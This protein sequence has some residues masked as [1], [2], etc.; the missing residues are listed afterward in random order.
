MYQ[1]PK[2]TSKIG[3]TSPTLNL[4]PPPLPSLPH[5]DHPRRD[6]EPHP[7]NQARP[8]EPLGAI[9]PSPH[10]ANN[11][12][13]NRVPRQHGKTHNREHHPHPRALLPQ[14]R[15]Q[16]TQPRGEQTL[17]RARRDAVHAR[18]AVQLGRRVHGHPREQAH[19]A[20]EAR[21]DH[22]IQGPDLIREMI[23]E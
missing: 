14:I 2:S 15:R 13:G 1:Y 7:H 19:A 9:I 21:R 11:S 18:P 4:H 5:P 23:R 22:H 20:R 16:A 8:G 3:P 12:P 6:Q 17:Q 10:R